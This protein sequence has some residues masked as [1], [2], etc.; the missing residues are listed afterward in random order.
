RMLLPR[1]LY[2]MTASATAGKTEAETCLEQK[3]WSEYKD[4]W[5]VRTALTSELS[6]GGYQVYL[7][8]LY[9]GAEYRFQVCGDHGTADVD[10]V[11]QKSDGAEPLRDST[12]VQE[13]AI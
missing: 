3:V 2:A 7:M 11:L 8:T 12:D 4:G 6:E 10:I 5:Q 9:Y 13:N 1:A